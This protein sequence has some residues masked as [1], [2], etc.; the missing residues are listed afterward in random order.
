MRFSKEYKKLS[1]PIFTTIRK[2]KG[3]Y[4]R[5]NVFQVRTPKRKFPVRV[6]ARIKIRK[7]DIDEHLAR[8]DADCSR[9]ELL[10]ML[11]RWYG[12][13]FDN[14]LLLILVKIGPERKIRS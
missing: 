14:Y 1:W 2:N 10:E 11:E 12:P 5:E 9:E 13:D 6:L 7:D 3:Y 4:R 8:I